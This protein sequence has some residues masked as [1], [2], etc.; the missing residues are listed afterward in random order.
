M[1][2]ILIELFSEEIPAGAQR[3]AAIFLRD[4]ILANLKN[5]NI[6]DCEARYFFSPRRLTIVIDNLPKI[7]KT[8]AKDIR[9]PKTSAPTQAIEGFIRKIGLYDVSQLSKQKI[10]EDNYYYYIESASEL[11]LIDL[12]PELLIESFNK[13]SNFWPKTMRWGSNTLRWMR[14]L[15]NI[16][17]VFDGNIVP[18]NYFHLTSNNEILAHRL[19]NSA[20]QKVKNFAEY[21][22]FLNKNQVVFDHQTRREIIWNSLQDKAKVAGLELVLDEDLLDEVTGLVEYPNVL[23]GEF[24]AGFLRLPKEALISVM[25]KHQRYFALTDQSGY[26]TNKFLFVANMDYSKQDSA[27]ERNVILGNEY[28]LTARFN[29]A[30]FFFQHDQNIQLIERVAKLDQIIYH[31]ELGSLGQKVGYVTALAKFI[32]VFVPHSDLLLVERASLLCKCDLTTDLVEEL[33]ELQGVA[34]YYYA[35]KGGEVP[36]VATAIRDHY[37]PIGSKGEIPTD[38]IT[39]SVALADK[40]NSLVALFVAGE[41]PSGSKD[42]YA[43]RRLAI[44]IIN[45]IIENK[46]NISLKIVIEYA[47]H[48]YA[49]I[50]KQKNKAGISEIFKNQESKVIE[51]IMAFIIE[52]FHGLMNSRNITSDFVDA[53]YNNG[54]SDDLYVMYQKAKILVD[55]INDAGFMRTIS[56]Y[57]RAFNIYTRAEA[58]DNKVYNKK[59][60]KISFKHE[61]EK[62]LFDAN[63]NLKEK[64]IDNIKA[65]DYQNAFKELESIA[66]PV[67]IFFDEI[68]VND[69]DSQVR[70]NRLK[71]LATLCTTVNKF[72]NLSYI[73]SK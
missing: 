5:L 58:K 4:Q 66:S 49:C 26:L 11:S 52:R 57:K 48:H 51:Q 56:A 16:A 8:D 47:V 24:A 35:L 12:L 50:I 23:M 31:R 38:P 29:D 2:E 30:K 7:V 65:Q 19:L 45:I 33:P 20:Q 17:V 39:V 61:V 36:E 62:D 71:L 34:G 27:V 14:P 63:K 43:L 3:S 70:E 46:L 21:Q 72:A 9:G 53:V 73:K 40:I 28:V 22:D 42:P 68:M 64:I 25:K 10:K 13:L 69:P 55:Y 44:A 6:V 41:R 54:N 59:L 67:E 37:M 1:T 15:H 32:S 18:F 60:L